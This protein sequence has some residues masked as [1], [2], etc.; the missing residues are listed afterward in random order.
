ML[1]RFKALQ[2]GQGNSALRP[3]FP[4]L[5]KGTPL[6]RPPYSTPRTL[7]VWVDRDVIDLPRSFDVAGWFG[8][9]PG[10]PWA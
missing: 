3:V 1:F 7:G 9:G 2:D 5:L 6:N 4:L 8:Y 10:V